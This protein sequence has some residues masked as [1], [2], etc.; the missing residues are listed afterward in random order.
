MI[1]PL[2]PPHAVKKLRIGLKLTACDTLLIHNP[3]RVATT[4]EPLTS[5]DLFGY[6]RSRVADIE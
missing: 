6:C 3:F 2:V 4:T 1:F 5:L